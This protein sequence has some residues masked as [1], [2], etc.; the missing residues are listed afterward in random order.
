M[1]KIW[2][3]T[4]WRWRGD[5]EHRNPDLPVKQQID[6]TVRSK[7]SSSPSLKLSNFLQEE[8][9]KFLPDLSSHC[10]TASGHTGCSFH[11]TCWP[12]TRLLV[13]SFV[14]FW[15][16]FRFK[17]VL[18]R[19]CDLGSFTVGPS[20]AVFVASFA[21]NMLFDNN[22]IT[23]LTD[24]L[25][26][27]EMWSDL[28]KQRRVKSMTISWPRLLSSFSFQIKMCVCTLNNHENEFQPLGFI[29]LIS[30]RICKIQEEEETETHGR[31]SRSRTRRPDD[32][33]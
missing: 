22:I 19:Y 4:W 8:A 5:D 25:F 13:K 30:L 21:A 12:F 16:Q 27:R 1:E 17:S 2:E 7:Q 10:S 28:F 14:I 20:L 9:I 29:R 32:D 18:L 11:A 33:R 6:T 23:N 15:V 31:V 3:R 24:N 26:I